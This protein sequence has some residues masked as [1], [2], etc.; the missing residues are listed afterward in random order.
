MTL[1]LYLAPIYGCLNR[2]QSNLTPEAAAQLWPRLEE[3]AEKLGTRLGSPSAAVCGANCIER[4]P[5]DWWDQFFGNCS[6]CRVD[7]I[8]T[9]FYTCSP[10]HLQW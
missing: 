5:F 3:A 6:D 7:F 2:E 1:M 9:H 8:A 10:Q 4:N